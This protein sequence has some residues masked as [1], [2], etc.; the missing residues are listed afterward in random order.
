[1]QCNTRLAIG[2]SGF[3]SRSDC[4]YCTR[5]HNRR[6]ADKGLA[7]ATGPKWIL[8]FA[9]RQFE[10]ESAKRFSLLWREAHLARYSSDS[11]RA[12]D[13]F[14]Q[15][16]IIVAGLDSDRQAHSFEM[17]LDARGRLEQQERFLAKDRSDVEGDPAKLGHLNG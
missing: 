9:G 1:L 5:F 14:R 2:F 15:S 16:C 6:S 4:S 11:R 7:T 12:C 17:L 8:P 13:L 3:P 10:T